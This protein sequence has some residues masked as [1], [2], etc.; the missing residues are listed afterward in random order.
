MPRSPFRRS[1]RPPVA[2]R[3]RS[4]WILV[5]LLVVL[6]WLVGTGLA[7]AL[8]SPGTAPPQVIATATSLP[9]V[10]LDG[11]TDPVAPAQAVGRDLYRQACAT[12]HLGI[13]PQVFPD[14]T[15]QALL[16]D[17]QHYGA[18]LTLP[19]GGDLQDIWRYLREHSRSI[20]SEEILPYRFG[21]SSLF[22][23]LHPNVTLPRPVT[24]QTCVSCHPRAEFYN[25][26]VRSPEW[27]N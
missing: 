26:R 1:P 16:A 2:A 17:P 15:W 25:F 3:R 10:D 23:A 8:D 24:V 14:R 13:P 5:G 22:R 6:S 7:G 9:P 11:A 19:E 18:R 20:S 21:Q 12:C 27:E 4:P